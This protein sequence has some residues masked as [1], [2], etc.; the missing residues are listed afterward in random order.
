MGMRGRW[1]CLLLGRIRLVE[2]YMMSCRRSSFGLL[3]RQLRSVKFS[4]LLTVQKV[5]ELR[6]RGGE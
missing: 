4:W 6:D 2:A 1:G 3:V 5:T